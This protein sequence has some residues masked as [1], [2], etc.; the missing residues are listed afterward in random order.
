MCFGPSL[1]LCPYARLLASNNQDHLSYLTCF[2]RWLWL[3]QGQRE[4]GT[5]PL[6]V[7]RHG[8]WSQR[9]PLCPLRHAETLA[10]LREQPPCT[11]GAGPHQRG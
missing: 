7:P 6:A 8:P 3:E 2:A 9:Q 4:V 1:L 11:A 10:G 5:V